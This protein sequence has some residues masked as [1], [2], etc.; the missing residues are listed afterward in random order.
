MLVKNLFEIRYEEAHEKTVRSW[1]VIRGEEIG[2]NN[3]KFIDDDLVE[4]H[5]AI[6][7]HVDGW[8]ELY[9]IIFG[10]GEMKINDETK[11]VREG[12]LIFIPKGS[13]HSLRN[14]SERP[15]RFICIAITK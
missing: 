14:T 12:D 3:L 11:E 13:S 9:Y 4:P 10:K 8:D 15:L 2:N 5:M 7:E 1:R 6:K